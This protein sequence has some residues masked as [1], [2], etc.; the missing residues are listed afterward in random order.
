MVKDAVDIEVNN[1]IVAFAVLQMPCPERHWDQS[2]AAKNA[3][4]EDAVANADTVI[5]AV[6]NNRGV[7]IVAVAVMV[8]VDVI[9]AMTLCEVGTSLRTKC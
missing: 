5:A 8:V 1:L 7:I 2:T 6:N 3:Q 9:V 4:A